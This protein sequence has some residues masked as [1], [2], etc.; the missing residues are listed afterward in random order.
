LVS[1]LIVMLPSLP[2]LTMDPGFRRD[3][4]RRKFALLPSLA[5]DPGH[6]LAG[7]TMKRH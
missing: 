2:S 7:M 3:N 6:S 1:I 4:G 5:L